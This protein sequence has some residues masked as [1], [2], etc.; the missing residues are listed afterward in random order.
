MWEVGGNKWCVTKRIDTGLG[1]VYKSKKK[2]SCCDA[3]SLD[4]T[5]TVTDLDGPVFGIVSLTIQV[6]RDK[7]TRPWIPIVEEK[8][9]ERPIDKFIKQDLK[10]QLVFGHTSLSSVYSVSKSNR[11][12]G[13][14]QLVKDGH[15]GICSGY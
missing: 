5:D 8:V 9:H 2:R 3:N 14:V 4:P 11:T 10:T 13:R 15:I 6:K 7:E 1:P 12:R